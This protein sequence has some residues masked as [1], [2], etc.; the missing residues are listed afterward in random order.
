MLTVEELI[1]L[2]QLEEQ[3]KEQKEESER[4]ESVQEEPPARKDTYLG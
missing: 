1:F 3:E 4:R 2:E